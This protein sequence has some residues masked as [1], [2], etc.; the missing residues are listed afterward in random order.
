MK[1]FWITSQYD[2]PLVVIP[3]VLI[4]DSLLLQPLNYRIYIALKQV[5]KFL[6]PRKIAAVI[7]GCLLFSI[8]LNS[9]THY[10][11]SH[12]SSTGFMDPQ[13]G[14]MSLAGWWYYCFS[15]L[16]MALI[17]A[18]AVFWILTVKFQDPSMFKAFENALYI[19][20]VFILVNISGTFVNKNL[21]LRRQFNPDLSLP[22]LVNALTPLIISIVLLFFMRKS[23]KSVE[24][25]ELP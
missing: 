4:G 15:I 21:F 14:Q 7:V 6:E 9:Y 1:G 22:S 8:M 25:T 20:I 12:T 2:F 11:S 3:A 13:F 24:K 17:F 5:L 23:H 19:F 16:Q 18:F 10:L